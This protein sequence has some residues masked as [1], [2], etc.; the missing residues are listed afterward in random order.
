MYYLVQKELKKDYK[1]PSTDKWICQMSYVHT[2]EFSLKRE[3]NSD[4]YNNMDEP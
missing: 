1:Y 4:I 3:E 2:M